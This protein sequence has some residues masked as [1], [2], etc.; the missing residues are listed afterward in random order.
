M[1]D[2]SEKT[3]RCAK[4]RKHACNQ[5]EMQMPEVEK[6]DCLFI[7]SSLLLCLPSLYPFSLLSLS[8]LSL[9]LFFLCS[10]VCL[11]LFSPSIAPPSP[12]H[13]T[14]LNHLYE[15]DR[16]SSF[17]QAYY[18]PLSKM[19]E[20]LIQTCT[21]AHAHTDTS[22]SLS[23]PLSPSLSLTRTHA[24]LDTLGCGAVELKI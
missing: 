20:T 16:R 14:V 23:H 1:T 12:A 9:S 7:L 21:H 4:E 10:S 24:R 3:Q 13:P 8:L 6:K 11:M 15:C 2:R 18:L 19:L 17:G 22:L 5:L